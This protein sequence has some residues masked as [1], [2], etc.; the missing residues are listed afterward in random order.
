MLT[1]LFDMNMLWEEY[2]FRIL[3]KNKAENITVSFQNKKD[4]WKSD[5]RIKTI[6]P[7][8]VI[9]ETVN[10]ITTTYVIDTKWKIR[11][12]NNPDDNDLKQMFAYNLLW[13]AEKSLLLFPKINQDDSSFGNYNHLSNKMENNKCKLGFVSVIDNNHSNDGKQLSEEILKKLII[14]F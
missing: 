12:N 3:Q 10:Q 7:D 6:R 5:N 4:F 13:E 2:I 11:A 8:I 14:T 1:L 9:K